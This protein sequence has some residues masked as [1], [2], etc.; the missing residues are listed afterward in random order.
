M[1]YLLWLAAAQRK[2]E[3]LHAIPICTHQM[4]GIAIR[5]HARPRCLPYA[6]FVLVY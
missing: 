5:T 2:D 3:H 4:L 6:V 1:V